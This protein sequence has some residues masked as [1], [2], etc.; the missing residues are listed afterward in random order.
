M[1]QDDV[2][3]VD[4]MGLGDVQDLVAASEPRRQVHLH[5]EPGLHLGDAGAGEA[6][7]L[8]AVKSCP[9]PISPMMPGGAPSSPCS[10]SARISSRD[11]LGVHALDRFWLRSIEVEAGTGDDLD[12]RCGG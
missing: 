11:L 8:R 1:A 5:R 2:T 6:G 10:R 7:A 4:A 9:T 3:G 12:A